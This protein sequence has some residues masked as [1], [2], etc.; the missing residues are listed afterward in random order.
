MLSLV[1][2][3]SESRELTEFPFPVEIWKIKD[4]LVR[5]SYGLPGKA[6]TLWVLILS[7]YHPVG[8][9]NVS[10]RVTFWL[11]FL[12]PSF[13]CISGTGSALMRNKA[14]LNHFNWVTL[15]TWFTLARGS[16]HLTLILDRHFFRIHE[17]DLSNWAKTSSP[18]EESLNLSTISTELEPV[19]KTPSWVC[20]S[21]VY[22]CHVRW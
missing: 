2:W 12:L 8:F 5:E 3:G 14:I 1:M 9:W 13:I 19:L 20:W 6:W 10:H 16:S 7:R 15:S 11:I 21:P 18:W 4:Q 22:Q 17:N